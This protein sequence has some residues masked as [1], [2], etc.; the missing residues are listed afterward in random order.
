MVNRMRPAGWRLMAAACV[1]VGWT[2]RAAAQDR[3][4]VFLSLRDAE[5]N[6][7]SSLSR[8]EI[9]IT[10]GGE[11]RFVLNIVNIGRRGWR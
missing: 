10:E 1:L 6:A 5:G 8:D 11:S 4:Q 2:L 7:P 3:V 9:Q